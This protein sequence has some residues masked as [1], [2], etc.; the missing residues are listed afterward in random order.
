[1]ENKIEV[2]WIE[3][4]KS[5]YAISTHNKHK[6]FTRTLTLSTMSLTLLSYL[7]RR[8]VVHAA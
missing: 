8:T 4:Y 7:V 6:P 5:I 1:M 3:R 2:A